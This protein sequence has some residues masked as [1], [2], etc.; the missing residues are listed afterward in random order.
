MVE[1]D[2]PCNE[3]TFRRG[4]CRR[5]HTILGSHADYSLLD[6]YTEEPEA[7]L[8]VKA[9]GDRA[10]GLCI[11]IQDGIACE[12]PP[13]ARGFCR[14][15]YR[16]IHERG[17]LDALGL[18]PRSRYAPHGAANDLP[19]GY[20]D[21]NVLFDHADHVVFATPGQEGSVQL[22]EQARRG[23][24]RA[25]VSIDAVKTTYNHLRH[26][27]QRPL[28]EGGKSLE[29]EDAERIARDYV[30]DTF[31][32]GGAW[33]FVAL[34]A[35]QIGAVVLRDDTALSLEDALELEAYES[36]CRGRA[37]PTWFVTRD[38]DF[39]EGVHPTHLAREL[40]WLQPAAK[41]TQPRET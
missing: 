15:H 32:R 6:F 2:V 9:E 18:P 12:A 5:H 1:D 41:R 20:L 31:F 37:A 11:A 21:K 13:L 17:L 29:E 34:A 28:E 3:P 4:V 36:T 7:E 23:A 14:R 40:G 26:R 33:R 24:F 22:V 25:S 39:L 19:H 38:T 35:A 30:R 27:L 10:D 16:Y 8:R